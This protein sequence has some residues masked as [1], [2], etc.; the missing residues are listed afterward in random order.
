M[1][2]LETVLVENDI[3]T[4]LRIS[5]KDSLPVYYNQKSQKQGFHGHKNEKG[6]MLWSEE[7]MN[8]L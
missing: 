6:G 2:A 3:T 8:V 7:Q 5:T 1:K 4:D